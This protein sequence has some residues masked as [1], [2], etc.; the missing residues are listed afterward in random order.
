MGRT[1]IKFTD[2]TTGK[3]Y[4][5]EW[6]SI[7][8]A[9]ITF[10]MDWESFQKHY[11][12]QYGNEGMKDLPERMDRVNKNGHSSIFSGSV[13]DFIADNCAGKDGTELTIA[14]I[15]EHYCFNRNKNPPRGKRTC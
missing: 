9:P 7:V 12:K 8:D 3:E 5:L 11:R 2:Q 4:F 6:S 10:G 14:E 1:I 15:I 13:E